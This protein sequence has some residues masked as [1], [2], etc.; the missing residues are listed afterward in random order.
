MKNGTLLLKTSK[1]D[2][3]LMMQVGYTDSFFPMS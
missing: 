1:T 3:E 2:L